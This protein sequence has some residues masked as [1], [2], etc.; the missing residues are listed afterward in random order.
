MM[1]MIC[2]IYTAL[3]FDSDK[4]NHKCWG[5]W[6]INKAALNSNN[7]EHL[8]WRLGIQQ[9]VCDDHMVFCVHLSASMF[10]LLHYEM[11]QKADFSELW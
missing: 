1:V 3:M 10:E 9:V 4:L 2:Y 7:V 6:K 8:M 11:F 5:D